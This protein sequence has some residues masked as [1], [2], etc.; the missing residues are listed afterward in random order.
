MSQKSLT[1]RQLFAACGLGYPTSEE[2]YR[3]EESLGSNCGTGVP[4]DAHKRQAA[5]EVELYRDAERRRQYEESYPKGEK[6]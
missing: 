6:A 2:L 5:R 3:F 4:S 1:E